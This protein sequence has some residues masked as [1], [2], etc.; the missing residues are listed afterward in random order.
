MLAQVER[1][2]KQA[3]VH[4]NPCVASSALLCGLYLYSVAPEVVRRWVNEFYQ[5]LTYEDELV[6]YH[7]LLLLYAMK[8]N[9][10]LALTKLVTQ[11]RQHLPTSPLAICMLIRYSVRLLSEDDTGD[12][13]R[14]VYE[15]LL[16]FLRHSSDVA[17]F[18]LLHRRW[19]VSRLRARWWRFPTYETRTCSR[20]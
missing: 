6:Q 9:D 7:G 5:S 14:D 4:K 18:L 2:I 3:I 8:Q 16:K 20:W 19:S 12:L 17:L 15:M 13:A 1:Y 10:T 11:L